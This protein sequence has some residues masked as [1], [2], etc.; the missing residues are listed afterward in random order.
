VLGP[1]AQKALKEAFEPLR[2][3]IRTICRNAESQASNDPTH[4]DEASR[5]VISHTKPLLAALDALLPPGDATRDAVHDEVAVCALRCQVSYGNRTENWKVSLELLELALPIASGQAVRERIQENINTVKANLEYG[6][7]WFC[8]QNLAEDNASLEVKMYGD[9]IRTPTWN[10]VEIKWRHGTVKVPRC[11]SCRAAHG[12]KDACAV[13]G[14]ILGGILGLGGCAA[15][16][17]NDEDMW[18][19]GL[20]V[21]ALL[22]GIGAGIGAAIGAALRPR[23]VKPES[24]KNEFPSVKQLLSQGWQFGERPDTE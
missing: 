15:I 16:V 23:G 9:V 10:G 12:R 21:L 11:D 2:Q 7:C 5:E 14:G 18:F 22:A 3:R 8:K 20:L 4:G 17:S 6:T 24:A 13:A 1:L 19:G